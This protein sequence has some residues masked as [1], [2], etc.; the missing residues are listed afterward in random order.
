MAVDLFTLDSSRSQAAIISGLFLFVLIIA[1]QVSIQRKQ[2]EILKRSAAEIHAGKAQLDRQRAAVDSLAEGLDVAIFICD[3]RG[4]IQYANRRAHE[5]FRIQ[6][7]V[8]RSILSVTLSGDLQQLVISAANTKSVQRSEVTFSYPAEGVGLATAWPGLEESD[9]IFLSVYEITHLRRLERVRQDF[10]SNV[11]HELR[12]PLTIIRSMTETL[13]DEDPPN[14]ELA[15]RY[16]PKII[17]EV[18]RLSLISN[19][20][21][22]LSAAES[23]PVRRQSTDIAEIFKS[24]VEQLT[25]K[26]LDKGLS[27]SY[28]GPASLIIAANSSQMAQVAINLIDNAINYTQAGKVEVEVAEQE[29]S[30][31]VRV[32]DTGIGIEGEHLPR[33]FERFYRV[34]KAR[35]RV[36][37]GTGLGLSIVKHLVE[38]H[39]GSIQVDSKLNEGS[40]FEIRLP[41]HAPLDGPQ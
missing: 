29:D 13:L 25:R 31:I 21:L 10:V 20:L 39:G 34:D 8:G 23:N 18:D 22:I 32:K 3:G 14:A 41:I 28:R 36:T 37:G 17:S 2:Q 6:E 5:L 11:S 1:W 9:N 4:S 38:A 33:I 40:T 26:A 30:A 19:D 35:S 15:A 16:L 24:T 27:I 12:T 7:A